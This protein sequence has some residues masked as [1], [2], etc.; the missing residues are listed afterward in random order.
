VIRKQKGAMLCHTKYMGCTPIELIN[1]PA[2][3]PFH[4]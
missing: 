4:I 2:Y 3:Q 1:H